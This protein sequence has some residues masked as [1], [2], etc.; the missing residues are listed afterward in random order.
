MFATL[1]GV[2]GLS[3]LLSGFNNGHKF[4]NF[5]RYF[6]GIATFGGSLVWKVYGK[7][8]GKQTAHPHPIFLG[9]PPRD[10]IKLIKVQ[11]EQ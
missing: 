5:R 3:P 8:F 11:R 10:F 1:G 7:G 9:V 4:L 6:W 2:A